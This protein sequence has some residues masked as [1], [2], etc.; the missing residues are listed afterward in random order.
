M[1]ALVGRRIVN[2][3]AVHQADALNTLLRAKGAVPL[4]YPCIAFVPPEDTAPLDAALVDLIS[5]QFDWLILTSSN[6]VRAI[7]EHLRQTYFKNQKDTAYR[8]AAST[9]NL[10]M[11]S[12]L[13]PLLS[14]VSFRTAAVGSATAAAAQEMGLTI[15]HLPDD[16]V[17]ESLAES[18]PLAP[19]MRVL[20]PESA[21]ARPTLA[22]RLIDRGAN[23]TVV[24]AYQTVCG[25]GGAD[26][27]GFIAQ[28]KIDALTFTSSSTVTCFLERL[29]HE[30]GQ[31]EQA[32]ELAAACIGQKTAAT[33]RECGFKTIT[34]SDENTL[35][36]L[37][38][39]LDV[40]FASNI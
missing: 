10:E 6:T 36:G 34:M 25:Q 14:N 38:A 1:T 20:L 30:G 27:P 32:L 18:L 19:G 4:D 15:A 12:H 13:A 28:K 3:R 11:A 8:V 33:A 7:A 2:T 37:V 31:R 16:Y 40:Q 17:A 39:A 24:T 5:G 26:I 9:K 21:I 22:N 29:N 23:V 35:E